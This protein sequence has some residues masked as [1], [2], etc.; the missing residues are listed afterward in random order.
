MEIFV[1]PR[2]YTKKMQENSTYL[3]T[4]TQIKK[5]IK[6]QI[7]PGIQKQHTNDYNFTH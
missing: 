7:C 6:V 4:S 1:L 2:K 5:Y 3:L